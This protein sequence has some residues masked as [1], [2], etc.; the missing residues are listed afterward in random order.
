MQLMTRERKG[1][2]ANGA[3]KKEKSYEECDLSWF[4]NI[5]QVDGGATF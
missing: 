1:I 2:V 3:T 4:W 5:E